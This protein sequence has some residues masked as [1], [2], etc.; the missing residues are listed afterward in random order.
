VVLAVMHF[1]PLLPPVAV[2][3]ADHRAVRADELV[4]PLTWTTQKGWPWSRVCG[5][6]NPEDKSKGGRQALPLVCW[7]MARMRG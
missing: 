6:S 4:L 3:R 2:G 1:P 5:C 7:E